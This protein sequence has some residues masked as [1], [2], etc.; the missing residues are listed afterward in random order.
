MW[1]WLN[2]LLAGSEETR[3][4]SRY[5]LAPDADLDPELID[6]LEGHVRWVASW[7]NSPAR[8]AA[9]ESF[10]VRPSEDGN[11]RVIG[12]CWTQDTALGP[13]PRQIWIESALNLTDE[14]ATLIHEL[15]HAFCLS[16]ESHGRRFRRMYIVAWS[17]YFRANDFTVKY[18]ISSH[19]RRYQAGGFWA[20]RRENRELLNLVRE[21]RKAAA[22]AQGSASASRRAA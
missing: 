14:A 5:Y 18:Q 1:R 8:N 11:S 17:L 12:L 4:R 3:V 16:G 13:E 22:K 2:R 7:L 20:R 9:I 10:Q 6:K 19:L 15:C 21:T